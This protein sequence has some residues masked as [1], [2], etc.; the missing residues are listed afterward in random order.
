MIDCFDANAKVNGWF[1][2]VQ[3]SAVC[4]QRGPQSYTDPWNTLW[5]PWYDETNVNGRES[6]ADHA[7]R[8][9]DRWARRVRPAKQLQSRPAAGDVT[10]CV[11]FK[12]CSLST[13]CSRLLIEY[14]ASRTAPES[15]Q[16]GVNT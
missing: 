12:R 10:K 5:D 14:F 9:V 3:S 13:T 7:I 15:S 4:S 11:I 6:G 2:W 1:P 16:L 8:S